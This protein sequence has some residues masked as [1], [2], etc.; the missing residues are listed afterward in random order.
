MKVFVTGAT[1]FV[2]SAVVQ[3]LLAHGHEVLGLARN[4]DAARALSKIGVKPHPGDLTDLGSL[5]RGAELTDAVI[6]T[7]FI[8][9]FSKF[10]ESCEIDRL[11]IEAIGAE[12]VGSERP[13]II[14]SGIGILTA[15]GKIMQET[16]RPAADSK[17]PRIATE[18]AA[19]AVAALGVKVSVVRLPPTV[20]GDGDHGFVPLLIKLANEKQQAAY[21]GDGGNRWPAVHR[22]D[23]AK[24]YRLAL[25]TPVEI[26]TRYHAVAE[27]G[28][29]FKQIAETIG[30]Q[31]GFSVSSKNEA[32]AADYFGWFLHFAS[33]NCASAAT[34]TRKK[35][36]WIPKE[37]GIIEDLISGQYFSA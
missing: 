32:A 24:L 18:R 3:E 25:E 19:D 1:G 14:T 5:R 28:V 21:I 31:L 33:M 26:G 15:T 13:F 29:E 11:A 16:D 6:H 34:E 27:E 23:A 9:D 20:H 17:M 4:A 22:L 30:K 10:A 36:N 12:L 2:G 37:K 35:L 7:G 8:H